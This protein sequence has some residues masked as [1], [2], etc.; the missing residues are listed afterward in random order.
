LRREIIRPEE[1]LP[2]IGWLD[3]KSQRAV[4]GLAM[5]PLAALGC[6]CQGPKRYAESSREVW[7]VDAKRSSR[8]HTPARDEGTFKGKSEK[9]NGGQRVSVASRFTGFDDNRCRK[10][11]SE[12]SPTEKTPVSGRIEIIPYGNIYKVGICTLLTSTFCIIHP[13]T[14]MNCSYGES[15]MEKR[16]QEPWR[17]K[18]EERREKREEKKGLGRWLIPQ[19]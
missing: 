6:R 13:Y 1:S 9:A 8:A 16:R 19:R 15:N 17:E 2:S 5:I 14:I 18:R 12:T 10:W 11:S 3:D 7:L 4:A